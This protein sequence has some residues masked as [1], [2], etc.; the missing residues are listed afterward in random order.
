MHA[1]GIGA[2]VVGGKRTGEPSI[3]VYTVRKKPPSEIAPD[4]VIP[5]EID[6]VKTDVIEEEIP[7]L[8]MSLPDTSGDYRKSGLL[9]GIQIQPGKSEFGGTL[10]C[11]GATDDPQPAIVAITCHHVVAPALAFPSQS[12]LTDSISADRHSITIGGTNSAG[13]QVVLNIEIVPTGAG[14]GA[15]LFPIATYVTTAADTPSDIVD[16]LVSQIA[17]LAAPG[18]TVSRSFFG[19]TITIEPKPNFAATG[20][21]RIDRLFSELSDDNLT[22]TLMGNIDPGLL[23][24]A[25]LSI[26]LP[27]GKAQT[28]DAFWVTSEGDTLAS[29]AAGLAAEINKPALAGVTAVASGASVTVLQN[30]AG[31]S[32]SLRAGRLRGTGCSH[33]RI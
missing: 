30:S 22:F 13:L 5:A 10:G 14:A 23:V 11:I 4:E 1:V 32:F 31:P 24:D 2:K 8:Q 26:N 16:Q 25:T 9:G 29:I 6:G 7:R 15:S 28:F 21:L 19:S 20:N 12:T 18:A 27:G 17:P 33:R 3:I